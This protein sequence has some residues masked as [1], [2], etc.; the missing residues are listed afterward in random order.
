M[1]L[2]RPE[3]EYYPVLPINNF[4]SN[5]EVDKIIKDSKNL[6]HKDGTI[7][8]ISKFNSDNKSE[9]QQHMKNF[10]KGY[11]PSKRRSKI[12]WMEMTES[13]I[14]IY[15]KL[16]KKINEVNNN[17]FYLTLRYL[18]NL[19]FTE[20]NEN[21]QGFY[22]VHA[23]CSPES[24]MDSYVDIRKLSFVVQLSDP[25]DYEGGDLSLYFDSGFTEKSEK[26]MPK[27]K[28]TIIFF[29]SKIL[30]E[31]KPVTKGTRRSL[32]GWI[33]GPNVR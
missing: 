9:L 32:V 4:L 7:G 15:K 14:W 23:D 31:V 18:E 33:C 16:I 5:D 28:G 21:E 2:L 22:G 19:Q 1:Y 17:N 26:L 8:D 6:P 29:E 27:E 20:Y 10:D 3:K 13:N 12:K 11:V 24:S 30:H 25:S